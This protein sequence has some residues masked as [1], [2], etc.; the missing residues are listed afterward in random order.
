[1][2]S[3]ATSHT[4]NVANEI[5]FPLVTHMTH[6]DILFR[7]YGILKLC[8]SSEHVQDRPDFIGSVRFLGHKMGD[9]W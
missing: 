1:M 7:R 2:T 9:T 3:P 6:F 8:F 5:I 4:K